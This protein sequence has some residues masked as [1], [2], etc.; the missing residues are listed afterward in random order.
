MDQDVDKIGDTNGKINPY[1]EIIV[2]K[3]ERDNTILL[4]MEQW[5]VLNN[6]INYIQYDRLPRN[7]YNF[8]IKT[9][10][11]KSHMKM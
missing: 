8:D 10:D 11:Q 2:N 4:Q 6:V 9:M 3:A 1:H 7:F 5:S